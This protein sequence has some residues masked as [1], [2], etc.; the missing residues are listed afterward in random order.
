[1]PARVN[2]SKG[3]VELLAC[4][5]MGKKH[6]S[7]LVV[8]AAPEHIQVGLIVLGLE[9]VGGLEFQGDPETPRGDSVWIWAEW[10]VD[11]EHTLVRGEDLVHNYATKQPMQHTHW[12]FSGSEIVDGV[13]AA[14]MEQSIVTTYHD[15]YTIID[16]PL[17][18]GA[19]DTLYG[20]N[21]GF[22]PEV[23][24]PVTL[25]FKAD[26]EEPIAFDILSEEHGLVLPRSDENEEPTE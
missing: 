12:V 18:S 26:S 14:S 10:W 20:A 11:G 4:G 16:N 24:H 6:E 17:P 23:G 21:E 3:L 25:V 1:M 9:P 8:E 22:V 19:D 2:M 13:F 5:E 15:P 7:V